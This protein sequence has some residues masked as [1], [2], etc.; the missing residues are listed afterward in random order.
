MKKFQTGKWIVLIGLVAILAACGGGGGGGSTTDDGTN[1]ATSLAK[2]IGFDNPAS[3]VIAVFLAEQEGEP[4]VVVMRDPVTKDAGEIVYVFEDGS[5]A[6]VKPDSNGRLG[7]LTIDEHRFV[8][9]NY[10]D[11]NVTMTYYAP[12]GSV[13]VESVALVD[14]SSTTSQAKTSLAASIL[15]APEATDN[16]EQTI[17][18]Q[19]DEGLRWFQDPSN[20]QLHMSILR[21]AGESIAAKY[22]KLKSRAN[23]LWEKGVTFGKIVSNKLTCLTATASECAEV[24]AEETP[25]LISEL[26]A[27]DPNAQTTAGF[28]VTDSGIEPR[29]TEWDAAVLGGEVVIGANGSCVDGILASMTPG[30]PQY[31]PPSEPV[32]SV[33]Q[34]MILSTD[35]NTPLS[36]TLPAS[37]AD[38]FEIVRSPENGTFTKIDIVSGNFT[39]QPNNGYTGGDSFSF[40]A[41]NGSAASGIAR[42]NE[43]VIKISVGGEI[44]EPTNPTAGVAPTIVSMSPTAGA[45]GTVVLIR[46]TGFDATNS[47]NNV[48]TINGVQAPVLYAPGATYLQ[49]GVPWVATT[50]AVSVT[51]P[52]GSVTAADVFTVL[53][54]TVD[55]ATDLTSDTACRTYW[56]PILQGTSWSATSAYALSDVSKTDVIAGGKIQDW[57]FTFAPSTNDFFD[58]NVHQTYLSTSS[59]PPFNFDA[60]GDGELHYWA[61]SMPERPPCR[62]NAGYVLFWPDRYEDGTLYIKTGYDITLVRK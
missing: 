14:N 38:Y 49:V 23:A 60:T 44:D 20:Y 11:T 29:K 19:T 15:H 53:T 57:T 54:D 43:G 37:G 46:G 16:G 17:D 8:F 42:S 51:T 56:Y 3:D 24:T 52:T 18:E 40:V 36:S 30:C 55:P 26:G 59:T 12:D 62:F 7:E 10:T 34:D 2:S 13:S 48:V 61:V 47:A 1:N 35:V 58:L 31:V 39:Y 9:T 45:P 32:A 50:G 5:L 41:I 28:L 21:W 4:A 6:T 27:I 25:Q 22:D 33:A